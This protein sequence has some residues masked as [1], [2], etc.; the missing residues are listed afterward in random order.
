MAQFIDEHTRE[1]LAAVL[2]P[3]TRPVRLVLFTQEHACAPCREQRQL[4]DEL[5]ALS[6]K[7]TVEV[8]DLVAD[9]RLASSYRVTRVPATAVVGEHDIGVRFVG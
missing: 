2:G 5:A 4:L 6:D 1:E 7:L 3:L 9:A 8:H